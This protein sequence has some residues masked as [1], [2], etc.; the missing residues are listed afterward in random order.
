MQ[1]NIIRICE[2]ADALLMLKDHTF[3]DFL[4]TWSERFPQKGKL[5]RIKEC[6]VRFGCGLREAKAFIDS[7]MV[8]DVVF[9][10]IGD[11]L[12]F[13]KK[14]G[15]FEWFLKVGDTWVCKG[16]VRNGLTEEEL[17]PKKTK[18]L[19]LCTDRRIRR[20]V[21]IDALAQDIYRQHWLFTDCY[22]RFGDEIWTTDDV[23]HITASSGSDLESLKTGFLENDFWS[24]RNHIEQYRKTHKN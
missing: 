12:L 21:D 2:R 8:D 6:K 22:Y 18:V 1:T 10:E 4:R 16:E 23:A 20:A 7:S 5:Q 13:R 3:D 11:S 17:F 24:I 14:N 19:V 9:F 15:S